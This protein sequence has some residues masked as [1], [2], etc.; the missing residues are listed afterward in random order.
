MFI[1]YLEHYRTE[2]GIPYIPILT[3][4]LELGIVVCNRYFLTDIH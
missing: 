4:V 1:A 2:N 3:K